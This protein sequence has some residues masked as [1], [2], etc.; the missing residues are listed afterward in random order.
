M[1][2]TLDLWYLSTGSSATDPRDPVKWG[3]IDL[4][5]PWYW[6]NV[7]CGTMVKG[8][9][10]FKASR[11][12]LVMVS[13][14]YW[15]WFKGSCANG[16]L[17]VLVQGSYGTGL[18]DLVVIYWSKGSRSS[19]TGPKG[20]P[21]EMIWWYRSR[22]SSGTGTKWYWYNG[23]SGNGPG[24]L[25]VL[26]QWY[27]SMGSSGSVQGLYGTGPGGDLWYLSNGFSGNVYQGPIALLYWFRASMDLYLSTV[28]SATGPGHLGSSY[29]GQGDLWFHSRGS[30]VLFRGSD[31]MKK[32][33]YE[34]GQGVPM[35]LVMGL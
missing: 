35:V 10:C 33:I 23:F 8:P 34:T 6:Y 16:G 20:D 31:V 19:G 13:E 14:I 30:M 17:A 12:L 9:N 5:V 22:G 21:V 3:S 15:H 7:S 32:G 24:D 1:E 2:G 26:D 29:T 28:S 25:M 27:W 11:D 18:M 4:V